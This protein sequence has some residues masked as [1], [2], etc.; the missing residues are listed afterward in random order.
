[1][2]S[3][4]WEEHNIITVHVWIQKHK[5]LQHP[6]SQRRLYQK[7]LQVQATSLVN[8][9]SDSSHNNQLCTHH[10]RDWNQ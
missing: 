9:W 8:D 10:V 1:M 4:E 2:L 5:Y 6:H 3:L 7:V